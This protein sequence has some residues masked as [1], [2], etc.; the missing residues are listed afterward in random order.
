MSFWKARACG[1][2]LKTNDDMLPPGKCKKP[3]QCP[4]HPGTTQTYSEAPPAAG[5]I[6]VDDLHTRQVSCNQKLKE[7]KEKKEKSDD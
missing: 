7:K 1:C 4:N 5:A 2:N 3:T 6:L